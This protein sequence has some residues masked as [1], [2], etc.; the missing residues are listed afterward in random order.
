MPS[1]IYLHFLD[2]DGQ[3][4]KASSDGLATDEGDL[5]VQGALMESA[6]GIMWPCDSV[7]SAA[8]YFE[9]NSELTEIRANCIAKLDLFH[10]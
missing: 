5:E 3:I 1:L 9:T 6:W 7:A 8:L 10:S 4:I 2:G